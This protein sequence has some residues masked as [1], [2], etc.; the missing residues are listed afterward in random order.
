MAKLRSEVYNR[1]RIVRFC[2]AGREVMATFRS[3]EKTPG[4]RSGIFDLS[5]G[6]LSDP[7]PDELPLHLPGADDRRRVL[8]VG[9][10]EVEVVR[11]LGDEE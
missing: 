5:L 7:L 10:A 1:G 2:D 4:I 11:A 3:E 9:A 8:R 6:R